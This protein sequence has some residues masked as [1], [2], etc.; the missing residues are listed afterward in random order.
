MKALGTFSLSRGYSEAYFKKACQVRRLIKQDFERAFGEVDLI[1]GPVSPSTAFKTAEKKDPLQLYLLDIFTIPANL[2]GL[3]AVSLPY[4][5]DCD[6][7]PIGIQL[8]ASPFC[9]ERLMSVAHALFLSK[10][11]GA[12]V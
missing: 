5:K 10:E 2:A 8:M 6:G 12:H 9:E 11:G 1:L 7:L 3:P 4:G